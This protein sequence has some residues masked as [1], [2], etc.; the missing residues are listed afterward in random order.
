[1]PP[2]LGRRQPY[3]EAVRRRQ[4]REALAQLRTGS[5]WGAAFL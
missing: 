4:Q 5:H 1:V 2:A 3:L